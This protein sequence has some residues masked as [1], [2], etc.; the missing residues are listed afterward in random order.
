MFPF[1]SPAA[2]IDLDISVVFQLALFLVLLVVLNKLVFRPLLALFQQRRDETDGRREE[3]LRAANEAEDLL[4][5][6]GSSMA[7]ATAEGMAVRSKVR[8]EA[9]RREAEVVAEARSETAAWY[10]GELAQFSVELEQ[11]RSEAHA[12]VSRLSVELVDLLVSRSVGEGGG[13]NP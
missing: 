5:S 3:A 12:G 11:A 2:I 9:V 1:F 10:E 8:D 7:E 4:D 13:D 6:Y